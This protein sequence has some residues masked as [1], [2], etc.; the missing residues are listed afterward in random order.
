MPHS[1]GGSWDAQLPAAH[2]TAPGIKSLPVLTVNPL[3]LIRFSSPLGQTK[4]ARSGSVAMKVT[5]T[6]R[7]ATTVRFYSRRILTATDKLRVKIY[8]NQN[9][10]MLE[11]IGA[12]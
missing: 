8:V 5:T 3:A 4:D 7:D 11:R 2:K 12:C 10:R 6:G 1:E 9:I